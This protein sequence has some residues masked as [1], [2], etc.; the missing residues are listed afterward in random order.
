MQLQVKPTLKGSLASKTCTVTLKIFLL[1]AVAFTMLNSGECV[2]GSILYLLTVGQSGKAPALNYLMRYWLCHCSRPKVCCTVSWGTCSMYC[3]TAV[4][5]FR[6]S[7]TAAACS[8][9]QLAMHFEL[10][11][12]S[13]SHPIGYFWPFQPKMHRRLQLDKVEVMSNLPN[14]KQVMSLFTQKHEVE[15]AMAAYKFCQIYKL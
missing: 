2:W 13:H 9:L 12:L 3:S 4:C 10:K 1:L 11:A 8:H 7:L 14:I 15:N 6:S 5:H